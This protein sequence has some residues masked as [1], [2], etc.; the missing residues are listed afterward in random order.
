MLNNGHCYGEK[1][2][3]SNIL[4]NVRFLDTGKRDGDRPVFDN[5]MQLIDL[6]LAAL[7]VMLQKSKPH[8][9]KGDAMLY[10]LLNDLNLDPSVNYFKL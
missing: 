1:D 10:L 9:S 6:P 8:M 7:I 3:L 5:M 2:V 4:D